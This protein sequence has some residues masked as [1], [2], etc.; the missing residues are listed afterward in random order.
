[1]LLGTKIS[2]NK[3]QVAGWGYKDYVVFLSGFFFGSVL[4]NYEES[5][6]IAEVI[7]SLA[8]NIYPNHP[9]NNLQPSIFPLPW[10]CLILL[11]NVRSMTLGNI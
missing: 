4:T 8:S 10:F 7:G 2:E 1:M 6:L 3:Q 5:S 11:S 9:L